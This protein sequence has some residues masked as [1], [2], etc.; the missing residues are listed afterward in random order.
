[1]KPAESPGPGANRVLLVLFAGVLMG[2][3]DIAIIG[4]ALPAVRDAFGVDERAASWMVTIYVLF[5]LVGTPLMAKLS[6][7]FGRRSVYAWDVGI[8]AAGSLVVAVAPGYGGVLAGRAIQGL[9]AGGIFPVASAVIGDIFPPER[10]GSALGLIG[11]V[12]GVAFLLGP[13][14]GGLLLML[15]WPW[16][17]LINLPIAALVILG[18]LRVLPRSGAVEPRPFDWGGMLL[19]AT[20]LT[21]LAVA[22]NQL[23]AADLVASVTSVAVWPLLVLAAATAA[24]FLAVERRAADPVIRP[25]L[26]RSRQVGI[27]SG[28]SL[29]A[30]LTESAVI[31]V[32]ALLVATFGVSASRAAFML[33][34]IVV[35]MGVG[36]PALGWLLDRVGSRIVVVASAGLIAAGMAMVA[37][38]HASLWLFYGA[39]MAIGVGLAGLMGSSLRYVM[40]NEA[41][42]ADRGAAQGIL[43][44]FISIGQLAGAAVLG[45]LIASESGGYGTAFMLVAAV[46]GLLTLSGLGLRSRSAERVVAARGPDR[47]GTGAGPGT[48]A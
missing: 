46:M 15:G 28:L 34:P 27:V 12:F 48:D 45:A 1:M 44:V 29:G 37:V 39:G 43:T 31:F 6:D 2:A 30:G 32:P 26:F 33:L 47:G 22:L 18:A 4:P 17:F 10:R 5:N 42:R 3:L 36:A 40:L 8:F 41:P 25:G 7:R 19:L 9:G 24:G 21:A 13:I 20:S 35:A 14:L 11:A 23:D 16:L 38:Y